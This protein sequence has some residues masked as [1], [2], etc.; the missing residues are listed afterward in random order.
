MQ[1]CAVSIPSNIAEGYGRD[2][3]NEFQR[4]LKIA[5]GSAY[6]L[7]TQLEIALDINYLTQEQYDELIGLNAEVMKLLYALR[8]AVLARIDRANS[9]F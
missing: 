7:D 5:A 6:E 9:K 1:R 2:S 8:K 3:D 4:F